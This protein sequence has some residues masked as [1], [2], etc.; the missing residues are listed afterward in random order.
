MDTE[1]RKK[2]GNRQISR[3]GG[4]RHLSPFFSYDKVNVRDGKA[5]LTFSPV[6]SSAPL[7]VCTFSTVF[8]AILFARHRDLSFST[9]ASPLPRVYLKICPCLRVVVPRIIVVSFG[10]IKKNINFIRNNGSACRSVD[11]C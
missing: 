1:E 4:H 9:A 10:V 2:K 8:C 3:G 7:L 5:S 6:A 11:E